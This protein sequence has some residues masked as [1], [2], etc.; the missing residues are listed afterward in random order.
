MQPID[1][2]PVHPSAVV[3]DCLISL[4]VAVWAIQKPAQ[5][6]KL[7]MA[8]R[9]LT[10]RKEQ[11]T[12]TPHPSYSEQRNRLQHK[13][14][15]AARLPLQPG[16]T[17]PPHIDSQAA[18][19]LC[20]I[21]KPKTLINSILVPQIDF[22]GLLATR[23]ELDCRRACRRQTLDSL[24]RREWSSVLGASLNLKGRQ[25]W[26]HRGNATSLAS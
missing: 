5:S 12:C 7:R 6:I 3:P 8:K 23:R 26:S 10:F 25:R 18:R 17:I 1:R 2:S 4:S 20:L 22:R 15:C 13:T 19:I 21:G 24:G 9:M 14:P 16:A 11:S